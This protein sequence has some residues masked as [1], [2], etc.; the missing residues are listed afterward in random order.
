VERLASDAEL[1]RRIGAR[2]REVQRE[3]FTWAKRTA[4]LLGDAHGPPDHGRRH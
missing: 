3:R 2:A 4:T 1:R